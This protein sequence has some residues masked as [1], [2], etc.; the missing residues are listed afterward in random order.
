M[1]EVQRLL[2]A[3]QA[4][5]NLLAT[6]TQLK[7]QMG[8][9]SA[10]K[11]SLD[12]AAEDLRAFV[13]SGQR[14]AIG[15]AESCETL[16]SLSMP[17][18][19][20]RVAALRELLEGLVES[21][22]IRAD[23]LSAD[24]RQNGQETSA[25]L[26]QQIDRSLTSISESNKSLLKEAHGQCVTLLDRLAQQ[27]RDQFAEGIASFHSSLN[28]FHDGI[29]RSVDAS[30][31]RASEVQEARLASMHSLQQNLVDASVQA[32]RADLAAATAAM[33]SAQAASDRSMRRLSRV[34]LYQSILL[35]LLA[36]ATLATL[37]LPFIR[38]G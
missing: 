24:V 34:V 13:Q 18:V 6:L 22:Q 35:G 8:G 2:D 27:S 3:E 11:V 12:R 10:A 14:L 32:T 38:G 19:L 30:L 16:K 28:Q 9:Y 1:E 21:M 33:A 23:A 25:L 37:V 20:T 15:A 5:H 29:A 36:T 31:A 4:T 26:S 17:E 7:E